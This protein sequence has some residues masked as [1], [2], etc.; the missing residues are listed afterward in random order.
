VRVP[1]AVVFVL[2]AGAGCSGGAG[3]DDTRCD[4]TASGYGS[5]CASFIRC[6]PDAPICVT[7]THDEVYG[8]C[9]RLCGDLFDCVTDAAVYGCVAFVTDIPGVDGGAFG[10]GFDCLGCPAG[11]ACGAGTQLCFPRQDAD[12]PDATVICAAD[13]GQ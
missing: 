5:V 12:Y 9:T 4:P 10:C 6:P 3:G 11:F 8:Y 2:G 13:A 1:L 7:R